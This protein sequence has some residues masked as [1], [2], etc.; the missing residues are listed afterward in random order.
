MG[1]EEKESVSKVEVES[2]KEKYNVLIP[3]FVI[4]IIFIAI[5]FFFTSPA[6]GGVKGLGAKIGGYS[7]EF[8][9][10]YI[11]RF[12]PFQEPEA[13]EALKKGIRIIDIKGSSK[14]LVGT[15]KLEYYIATEKY[16]DV[17]YNIECG[18]KGLE[19]KSSKLFG[20]KFNRDNSVCVVDFDSLKNK[21]N[22][23]KNIELA[24]RVS[25]SIDSKPY[26][27]VYLKK[28]ESEYVLKSQPVVK[29]NSG[30]LRVDIRFAGE[31]QPLI[32]NSF[33]ALEISLSNVWGYGGIIIN[34]IKI[35]LP[36]RIVKNCDW[37]E[38]EGMLLIPLEENYKLEDSSSFICSVKV[39]NVQEDPFLTRI[40]AYVDYRFISDDFV[41]NIQIISPKKTD[42]TEVA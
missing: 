20:G 26:L 24:S 8:A 28:R 23:K 10:K 17:D 15:P 16:E 1:D 12:N 21:I 29:G 7:G 35:K 31:E 3:I 37:E 32:E 2:K 13:K 40:N 22:D 41:K 5:Y 19:E 11:S 30:P 39:Q 34:E 9:S 27:D 18:I 33:S 6:F 36:D 42:L 38:R 25:F 4:A 14:Y